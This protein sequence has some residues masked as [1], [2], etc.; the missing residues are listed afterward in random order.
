MKKKITKG[1]VKCPLCNISVGNLYRHYFSKLHRLNGS[2]NAVQFRNT[3]LEDFKTHFEVIHE[4][5]QKE[6]MTNKDDVYW[7]KAKK[8]L[9]EEDYK[10]LERSIYEDKK[11]RARIRQK[12]D[13]RSRFV[14]GYIKC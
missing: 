14:K 5:R 8:E 2:R 9:S 4:K 13:R 6:I 1:G 10:K 12:P 7:Q 11:P 3:T